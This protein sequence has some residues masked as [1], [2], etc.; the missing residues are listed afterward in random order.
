MRGK[1]MY[2]KLKLL[3]VEDEQTIRDEMVEILGLDFEHIYTAK[4][5]KEGL[6]V[7]HEIKPDLVITDIQIPVMDGISMSEEIL[8]TD[9]DVKIILTTAF[10]EDGYL[11]KAREIGIT[12]YIN[13]PVN[14]S[15][16]FNSI[17]SILG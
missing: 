9:P 6:Q 16:L 1:D 7:Y 4:N 11:D 2:D 14:L 3:Y 8:A 10:N 17:E 5:G 12:N 13:K 15:E